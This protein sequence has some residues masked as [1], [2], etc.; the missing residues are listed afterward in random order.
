M[1]DCKVNIFILWTTKGALQCINIAMVK[2]FCQNSPACALFF[3]FIQETAVFKRETFEYF[4]HQQRKLFTLPRI[5]RIMTAID[6][7]VFL[8]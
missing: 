5:K 6:K 1:L 2:L 3:I 7:S 4:A 8:H